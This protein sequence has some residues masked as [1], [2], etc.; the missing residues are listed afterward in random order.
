MILKILA[1]ESVVNST[2][3]NHAFATTITQSNTY[4][5]TT[6]GANYSPNTVYSGN[7]TG[8]PVVRLYNSNTTTAFLITRNVNNSVNLSSVTIGPGQEM[9]LEKSAADFLQSNTAGNSI[10]AVPVA[11]KST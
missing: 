4:G 11:F 3:N 2:P 9:F 5:G 10:F 6:Q 8:A 7:N 1:A